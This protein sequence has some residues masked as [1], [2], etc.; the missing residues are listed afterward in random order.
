MKAI[1]LIGLVIIFISMLFIVLV[2]STMVR[3]NVECVSSDDN[4]QLLKCN[5]KEFSVSLVTGLIMLGFFMMVEVGA[6][7]LMFI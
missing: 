6:V 1:M 4:P 5:I 7:Y 3:A 2:I